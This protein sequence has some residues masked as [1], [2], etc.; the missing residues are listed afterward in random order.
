MSRK[1]TLGI[2]ISAL[3]V[4]ACQTID[5]YTREEKTSNATKGAAIGAAAGVVAG[6]ISGDSARERRQHALIGAG[7]GALAG[8]GIGYYMDVQE[9][10][11]RQQLEG[12]GVSISRYGNEIVLNMPGN[13][14]FG[15]AQ[16][17][18]QSSFYNVLDSVVLVL[19][20][21]DK[22]MIEITGHTDSR[23]SDSYNQDLSERR[24]QSVGSYLRSHGILSERIATQGMGERAPIANNATA[25]GQQ[26][27]RRVELRLVPITSPQSSS[28]SSY[29]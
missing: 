27:N 26:L 1:L 22:T 15:T 2:L 29:Y 5:P 28:R 19:Q 20:E 10:K 3:S 4:S 11:L 18:I 6:L 12:S 8:G 13:I 9:V 24:A 7:I 25:A 21:Y 17:A 16:A 14:T 23:G